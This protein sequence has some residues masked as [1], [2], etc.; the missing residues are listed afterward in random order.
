MSFDGLKIK[1]DIRYKI[2]MSRLSGRLFIVIVIIVI[3]IIF[4]LYFCNFC[5]R[6][7]LYKNTDIYKNNILFITFS[8]GIVYKN[9]R[10][11]SEANKSGFFKNVKGYNPDDFGNEFKIKHSDFIKNNKR[12]YGYWL[13]KPYLIL[14]SLMEIEYNDFLVYADSG[15]TI[16]SN[17]GFK[18]MR[19][20]YKLLETN[21]VIAF[22]IPFDELTWNKT[23]AIQSVLNRLNISQ[24]EFDSSIK[25][26]PRQTCATYML[27]KKT[28]NTMN[29]VNLWYELA[30]DYHNIDDSPSLIPNDVSFREHRHDQSLF[31]LITRFTPLVAIVNDDIYTDNKKKAIIDS[32]KR[33]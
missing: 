8:D 11:V 31:S 24:E 17:D 33:N 13:W 9:D 4:G 5:N 3:V 23:D 7:K 6:T 30:S 10:I 14:K 1:K 27:L 18:R 25:Q 29:M 22:R 15:C 20:L 32:R 19:E 12:G 16:N 26:N 2:K 21:D 28:P